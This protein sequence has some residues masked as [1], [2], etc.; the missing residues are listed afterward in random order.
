[1]ATATMTALRVARAATGRD[2]VLKFTGCYHGHADAFLVA[3]GSGVATLSLPDSPGVPAEVAGLTSV[4]RFNDLD[5]V[6]ELFRRDGERI[7]AV[8]VEPVIGNAGLIEP[9]PGFLLAEHRLAELVEVHPHPG[10]TAA[11]EVL[12]ELRFLGGEDDRGTLLTHLF[13]DQRHHD[14]RRPVL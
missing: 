14:L 3:A 4:V 12:A 5:A 2:G 11:P 1:M 8:F 7:A 6:E 13:G 10:T 9:V